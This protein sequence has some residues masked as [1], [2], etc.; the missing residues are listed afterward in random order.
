MKD[1]NGLKEG[2][3]FAIRHFLHEHELVFSTSEV[4]WEELLEQFRCRKCLGDVKVT[5]NV[6]STF[7]QF[8]LRIL[9]AN[10]VTFVSKSSLWH[11]RSLCVFHCIGL[12]CK[13]GMHIP[14]SSRHTKSITLAELSQQAVARL[15][16]T[17]PAALSILQST[18]IVVGSFDQSSPRHFQDLLPM[19]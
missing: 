1:I 10:A 18:A 7:T 16:K 19:S 6:A 4:V 2:E 15:L 17:L 3:R 14:I 13:S 8:A 9:R 12:G 5:L 11:Q